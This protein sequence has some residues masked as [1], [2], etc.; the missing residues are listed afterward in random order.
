MEELGEAEFADIDAS[1][2]GEL[3]ESI[4]EATDGHDIRFRGLYLCSDGVDDRQ[5]FGL[6]IEWQTPDRPLDAVKALQDVVLVAGSVRA[7][8]RQQ[9]SAAGPTQ[10]PDRDRQ[11]GR[12]R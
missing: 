6:A 9:C 5:E 2:P 8:G 12:L 11:S 3:E 7:H 10:T 1:C 4:A